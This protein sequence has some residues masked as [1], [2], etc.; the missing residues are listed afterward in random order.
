MFISWSWSP[1]SAKMSTVETVFLSPMYSW[2][3]VMTDGRRSSA[4]ADA[5]R[6]IPPPHPKPSDTEKMGFDAHS[7]AGWSGQWL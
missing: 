7:S 4:D 5:P 6:P 3:N 1:S 2:P